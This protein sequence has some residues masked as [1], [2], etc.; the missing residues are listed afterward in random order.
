MTQYDI[1]TALNFIL[2]RI[3]VVVLVGF[4]IFSVKLMLFAYLKKAGYEGTGQIGCIV[5]ILTT[6]FLLMIWYF[7]LPAGGPR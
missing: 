2:P 7:T 3:L 4:W 6:L 5:Y 1:D